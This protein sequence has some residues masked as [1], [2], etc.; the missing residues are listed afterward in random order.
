MNVGI[1]TIAEQFLSWEYLFRI[2][3]IVS[4]S[5]AIVLYT[6]YTQYTVYS[7]ECVNGS[8]KGL[9]HEIDFD[10]IVKI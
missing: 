10:N 2:F 1:G 6:L 3:G 4:F 9:S 7:T 5:V 8:L